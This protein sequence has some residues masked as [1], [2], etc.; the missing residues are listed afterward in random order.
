MKFRDGMELHRVT[1][2][3]AGETL[4]V[5]FLLVNSSIEPIWESRARL[6]SVHGKVWVVSRDALIQMKLAAGRPQDL[7]D[8]ENLREGDR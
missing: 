1:K 4:T 6:S 3:D 7:A 2:I 8:I 5:D